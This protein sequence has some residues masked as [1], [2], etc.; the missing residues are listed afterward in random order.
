MIC[1]FNRHS[2]SFAKFNANF[3]QNNKPK[4]SLNL[5]TVIY[6]ITKKFTVFSFR[7]AFKMATES[8]YHTTLKTSTKTNNSPKAKSHQLY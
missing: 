7:E 6:V 3:L 1:T 8:A 5:I 4:L 2:E